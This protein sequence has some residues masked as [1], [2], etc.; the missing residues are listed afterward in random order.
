MS[1]ETETIF[2]VPLDELPEGSMRAVR[3]GG[4][5]IVVCRVRGAVHA[6]D[7]VC[8]H[9]FARLSE[10]RLRGTRL[11]CPL[12]GA[13]FDVRDGRALGAPASRALDVFPARIV[14]DRVEIRVAAAPGAPKS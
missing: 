8:S 6:L 1:T 2:S 9:A 4:R 13:A 14:G 5:E 10:G 11:I 7:N 12:H 3:A